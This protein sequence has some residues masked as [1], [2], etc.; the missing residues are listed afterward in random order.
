MWKKKTIAEQATDD[1][2]PH[3]H[4]MLYTKAKNT[5]SEYVIFN[6]FTLYQQLHESATILRHTCIDCLV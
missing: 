2:M 3:A 1:N 4:C 5:H 6:A